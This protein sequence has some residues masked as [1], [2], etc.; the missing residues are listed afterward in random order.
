[1]KLSPLFLSMLMAWTVYSAEA[2]VIDNRPP[3]SMNL[4]KQQNLQSIALQKLAVDVEVLPALA[5]TH[6]TMTFYNPTHRP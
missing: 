3:V 6:L 2:R 1:M 4:T 5:Q